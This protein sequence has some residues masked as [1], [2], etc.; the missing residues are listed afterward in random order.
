VLAVVLAAAGYVGWKY[1]Y[2]WWKTKPPAASGKELQV[3]I[4]DVGPVNGDS[5]LIISS[6]A[7]AVLT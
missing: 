4:L 3:H 1:V 6:E 2:R 5:I 7:K